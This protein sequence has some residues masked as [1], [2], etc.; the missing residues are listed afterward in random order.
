MFWLLSFF[1]FIGL[2]L[3]F[4]LQVVKFLQLPSEELQLPKN[5]WWF[6][7]LVIVGFQVFIY[8]TNA[9]TSLPAVG[10]AGFFALISIGWWPII[11]KKNKNLWLSLI[12]TS[13]SLLSSIFV[14]WRSNGFLQTINLVVWLMAQ[15]FLTVTISQN[16]WSNSLKQFCAQL[17]SWAIKT[18]GNS[19]R[20]IFT[21]KIWMSLS[22]KRA[23]SLVKTVLVVIL[24]SGFF[25][26]IFTNADPVF[27]QLTKHLS[28]NSTGRIVSSLTIALLVTAG[29]WQTQ[30]SILPPI[31]KPIDQ[32]SVFSYRDLL[33]GLVSA[34]LVSLVFIGIQ[35][36]YLFFGSMELKFANETHH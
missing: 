17:F 31:K 35:F 1:G 29:L 30:K 24:V 27:A 28:I 18:A 9:N 15:V 16:T 12:V 20:L 4:C 11:I 36:R 21:P 2:I 5:F 22:T 33:A 19:V 26:I 6:L 32:P 25:I 14:L 3:A 7:A 8:G 23:G 10:L 34:L 13:A